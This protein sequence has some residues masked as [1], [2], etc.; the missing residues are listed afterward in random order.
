MP[1]EA[2]VVRL[3]DLHIGSLDKLVTESEQSGF[4]FLRR[5]VAEWD[6]R[7]NRFSRRGEALFGADVAG[8][9]VGV[10]GLNVDQYLPAERVGRVRHLYVSAAFRRRGVGS[11]L[12]AAVIHAAQGS[13][14]RL[15]LRAGTDPAA[16]FYE[17]IGFRPSDGEPDCT[18]VLE[19]MD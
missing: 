6:T 15:R 18:H 8:R 10:C 12:V 11:Q 3:C 2:V 4:L 19:L 16:R 9:I 14:D 13:F 1:A 5:L 7:E 17:A